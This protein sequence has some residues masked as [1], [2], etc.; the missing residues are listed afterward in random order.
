[1]SKSSKNLF[2]RVLAA[3]AL[4]LAGCSVGAGGE[5]PCVEDVS[6]P[7][8]FPVCGPAGKCIAGT[9][10]AQ[11]SVAIVGVDGRAAS[12]FLSGTVRVLV[13]ARAA[14]GVRT[15]T[16]A[17]GT[18]NFT[19]S[20]T[21][22]A[23]PLYAF[24]V[25]TTALA[26][27]DR[28]LTATVTAGDGSTATASGTLHV[29]NAQPTVQSFV[30]AG[31]STTAT[32][33]AGANI[34]LSATFAGGTGVITANT[35]E[36]LAI[37]SGTSVMVSPSDLTIY[38]LRVTSRSGVAVQTGT[39]GQPQNV[40]VSL[41]AAPTLSS[42][43]A[44]PA[45]VTNGAS[46]TL[47]FTIQSGACTVAGSCLITG[48]A[49][50]SF[51][52]PNGQN[53]GNPQS[54]P[55][56]PPPSTI[57]TYTLTVKNAATIP[58]TL[59]ASTTIQAI[60]SPAFTAG[61][62]SVAPSVITSDD[63][64]TTVTFTLPT[65]SSVA[66]AS[67][68]DAAN[69]TVVA[70]ALVPT[71]LTIVK[72]AVSTTYTL[73]ARNTAGS[74][75]QATTAVTVRPAADAD[76]TTLG[77]SATSGTV[78]TAVTLTP[79]FPAGYTGT[80]SGP[81]LSLAVSSGRGYPVTI[82]AAGTNSYTLQ[83][84]NDATPIATFTTAATH[85]TGVAVPVIA[86]FTASAPVVTNGSTVTFT[87]NVTGGDCATAGRC[88]I[89]GPSGFS[90]DVPAGNQGAD[91]VSTPATP[92]ANA[93]S[94]YALTMINA[95]GTAVGTVSRTLSVQAVAVP[96]ATLTASAAEVAKG[97][98]FTL[99]PTFTGA[100]S[101]YIA[102]DGGAVV[103]NT[104]T[105]G[106]A[107]GSITASRTNTYTVV[108]ANAAGTSVT[109]SV[110]VTVLNTVTQSAGATDA[111][112][113]ATAT[114]LNSG[115]VLIAGGGTTAGGNGTTS[116]VVYDP[117]VETYSSTGSLGTARRDHTAHLLSDGRV[118]LIGGYDDTGAPLRSL[119]AFD[120]NGN[121]GAGTFSVFT[122]AGGTSGGMVNARALHTSTVL[123]DGTLLV[124][125]G[126]GTVDCNNAVRSS[127]E[128]IN[129][130]TTSTAVSGT[131][132][133][134]HV[135]ATG[136]LL[137]SG[138]VLIAGGAT[139]AGGNGTDF[140]EIFSA[141]TF[142]CPGTSCS[143]RT[144]MA[145]ARNGHGALLLPNGQVALFGGKTNSGMTDTIELFNP[146][147]D[148]GKGTFTTNA[149]TL[150]SACWLLQATKLSGAGRLLI[151][152]GFTTGTSTPSTTL[153]LFDVSGTTL[154]AVT[155][156]D[157]LTTS[158]G[159]HTATLLFGGTALISGGTATTA[160]GE[161]FSSAQ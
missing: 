105:S 38:T 63:S 65:F 68:V 52:I 85:V 94:T 30:A 57:S 43:Q 114:L 152:G 109:D 108:V 77:S 127:S 28:A 136:T 2:S 44:S 111:R 20:T 140:A 91:H 18:V 129:I 92:P 70:N 128:I 96:T 14:T 104:L 13:S 134:E 25:D 80:I 34:A 154:T 21:A 66:S 123:A 157:P 155:D 27:G 102:D 5:I 83:V 51:D 139:S 124:A 11:A 150:G 133:S 45:T 24:D 61:A 119:E 130:S 6:C 106:T 147:G 81:G 26:D 113:G 72:P 64:N 59:Q 58:T 56:T 137:S 89:T 118:L 143:G 49:G 116:A 121:S 146:A 55:V 23:P 135:G 3:L 88:R 62:F 86:T 95:T 132:N 131:M 120:P 160:P 40:T 73:V 103:S 12:D 159:G 8:D 46:S 10:S 41:V 79:T 101:S 7:N 115:R 22:A 122:I 31:G 90:Y 145:T 149:A 16:L 110:T 37:A 69:T 158:R 76:N 15:V 144:P 99:T 1:M 93:T 112:F 54:T 17:A 84:E 100:A 78:G 50:F 74:V 67:I 117:I 4:V 151:S 107:T 142:T 35:G 156:I 138:K 98:T 42:F 53:D 161:I 71:N 153:D 47:T 19:A 141:G 60:A 29:D 125:G 32:V 36:S 97:S 33:T 82:P 126:C 87:Y 75:V 9:S 148:A 39:A 48:P